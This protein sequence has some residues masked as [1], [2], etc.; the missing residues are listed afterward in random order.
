MSPSK[1]L[2]STWFDPRVALG[3]SNVHG[4]G[5]F[6]TDAIRECEAVMVW[7]GDVYTAEELRAGKVPPG[8]WSYDEIDEG[9]F[10][11]AP[12]AGMDYFLNHS[13]D[14]NVWMADEVTVV[15]QR[16]IQPG[17][18]IA[19]DYALVKTRENYRLE[20]CRCGTARCR[21]TVTGS[22]WTLPELQARYRGRFMRHINR[23]IDRQRRD[24]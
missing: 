9:L 16:D 10:L 15:A 22:D 17:E 7:G 8:N 1:Y 11:F 3:P 2:P 21:G 13:C 4:Q 23:R 24:A 18:E 19:I 12:G 6:A 14:P 20:P 5:L